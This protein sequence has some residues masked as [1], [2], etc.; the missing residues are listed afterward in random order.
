MAD[1]LS[2]ADFSLFRRTALEAQWPLTVA[3]AAVPASVLCWVANPVP[4]EDLGSVILADLHLS[5]VPLLGFP[6]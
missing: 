3:P 2:K 1:A 6:V 4:D 5:G